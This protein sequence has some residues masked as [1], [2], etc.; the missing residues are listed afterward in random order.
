MTNTIDFDKLEKDTDKIAE[1][2]NQKNVFMELVLHDFPD[3]WSHND[4]FTFDDVDSFTQN[5]ADL[6]ISNLQTI[7]ASYTIPVDSDSLPTDVEVDGVVVA[8]TH[9]I[10]IS[11]QG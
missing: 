11:E 9:K 6:V 1:E 7:I 5:M 3:Y 8:T 10:D 2:S 4:Y